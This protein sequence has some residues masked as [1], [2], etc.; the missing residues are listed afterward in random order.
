MAWNPHYLADWAVMS[1]HHSLPL[2]ILRELGHQK[3]TSGYVSSNEVGRTKPAVALSNTN[4]LKVV[5]P[6][7]T[8][9]HRGL[10]VSGRGEVC[11]CCCYQ[12][13]GVTDDQGL[14]VQDV[15]MLSSRITH[16]GQRSI[17]V[18]FV[19]LMVAADIDHRIVEDVVGP[20]YSSSTHRDVAGQN[21]QVALR[22]GRLEVRELQ[23]QI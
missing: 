10:V 18:A 11:P 8:H 9:S 16:L 14:V 23:M 13:P 1:D 4:A 7:R 12:K 22:R 3:I 15:H 5:H 19:E 2:E 21:H 6:L 17:G 20:R